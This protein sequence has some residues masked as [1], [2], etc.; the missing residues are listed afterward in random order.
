MSS[1]ITPVVGGNGLEKQVDTYL[2]QQAV[3]PPG[4][5]IAPKGHATTFAFTGSE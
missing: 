5:A 1:V 2:F 3:S 4:Q